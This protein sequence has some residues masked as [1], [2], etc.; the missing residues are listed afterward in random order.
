MLH[1]ATLGSFERFI[2]ILVEETEGRM[3]LWLSPLQAV[4][5]NITD[6]QASYAQEAT[7]RL[8]NMGFRIESDLR[9][10]KIGFKIREWTLKRVPYILVVGDREMEAGELAIRSRDGKD[11]G[12]H[13]IDAI[14][15]AFEQEKSTKGESLVGALLGQTT[16]SA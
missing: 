14:S 16:E 15:K 5:V 6:K 1:R 9:N 4:V 11:L 8:Q 10:E 13:P 7:K 12:S 3:P 2:G